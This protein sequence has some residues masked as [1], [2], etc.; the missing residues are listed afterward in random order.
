MNQVLGLQK[1][2]NKGE[3]PGHGYWTTIA[4]IGWSTKSVNC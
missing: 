4:T 1:L 2:P 3:T